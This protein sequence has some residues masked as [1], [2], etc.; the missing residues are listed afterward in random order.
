MKKNTFT[1]ILL[2]IIGLVAGTLVGQLLV[3]VPALAFLT[4]T[5][6]LSWEPKADLLVFKFE[7]HFW[8]KPN[9]LSLIGLAAAFWIYRKL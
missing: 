6:D 3:Q 9:L 4:R 8:L 5:V 7:L 2:L 1:F